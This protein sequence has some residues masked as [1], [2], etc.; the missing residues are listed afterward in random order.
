MVDATARAEESLAAR[1]SRGMNA[2]TSPWGVVTDLT[3]ASA[4]AAIPLVLI[5]KQVGGGEARSALTYALAAIAAL[6]LAAAIGVSIALRDARASVVAWLAAQPFPIDN[7]NALLVG[8][9]DTF[10]VTFAAGAASPTR[11]RVQRL[12]EAISDDTLATEA[13]AEERRV[14]IQIGVIESKRVPLRSTYLRWVRFQRIVSEVL[15]PL[16]REIPIASIRLV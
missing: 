13:S 7:V 3:V 16:S 2:A 15:V 9:T 14:S 12:L 1:F 10:E 5:V 6:P 11:E 8:L 4:F